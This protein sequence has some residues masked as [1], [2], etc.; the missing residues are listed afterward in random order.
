MKI[1]NSHAL[2]SK[3]RFSRA[4]F[5]GI[6]S[7]LV[8][9]IAYGIF[10]MIFPIRFSILYVGIGWLIGR[11]IQVNGRGVQQKFSI[12]ASICAFASFLIS[13]LVS[14]VGLNFLPY[15]PSLFYLMISYLNSLNGIIHLVFMV[16][17]A[18][19]AYDQ[20]RIL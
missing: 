18:A 17:G 1:F 6:L 14:M 2:S 7:A 19:M 11:M 13:D 12:L 3:Q 5:V 4:L 9:G 16:V 8:L 15:L 10:N 20:A